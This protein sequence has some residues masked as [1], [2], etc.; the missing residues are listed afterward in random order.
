MTTLHF[1]DGFLWG[2]ATS[3]YQIEGEAGSRAPSIWHTFSHTP[4]KTK[5]GE[6]GDVACDHYNRWPEDV[7][8]MKEL[9]IQAYR[10]SVSWP[11]ILPEGK[12]WVNQKGLDFYGRLV[13]ALLEAGITPMVTLYHWE[14]PQPLQDAGGWPHRATMDA[15]VELADVTSHALGDRVKNW[16]TH[17][18]PWCT[19]F[20]SHQIGVHAPGWQ[21]W[22]AAFRAAHHVLLSHGHAVQQIRAN[23]PD[24]EVGIAI[25]FEPA[26]PANDSPEA[27]RAA[28]LWDGY[29][30][31]WFVDP[32][33]GRYYPA[34]MVNY[35]TQQGL[36]P[37]GLDF[38][39]DGDMETIAAPLDFF[40][41]NYYTRHLSP[42]GETPINPQFVRNPDAEYTLMNW[43]VHPDSFYK[44]L[45]RLYF[46][47]GMKKILITE[48]GCS[49][50]DAPHDPKRIEYLQ[51]HLTAVHRAIQNGVPIA[52]YMQWSFMDNYE[53]AEGYFQRF[54]IVH[55]DY[56][57]QK[58]TPKDSAYWYRDVIKAN[59]LEI[60]D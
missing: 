50:L 52:G 58:R 14:L 31:R 53:W 45:N 3:A 42:A 41:V 48:N 56:D 12:G 30:F 39:H 28:Q 44:L 22:G 1:P 26:S 46:E 11:R 43:E 35:Y 27:Y 51:G 36:L 38:I 32:L 21:D 10:F 2:V 47:Y 19:S 59:G 55:V 18:E 40:G 20:L 54:G 37:S 29:F 34:D 17:N 24:A 57:T 8:L 13:D 60:S 4:G 23:V 15:F 6:T 7:A 33:H 9:G 5:N 16:I 49:Y 25:N